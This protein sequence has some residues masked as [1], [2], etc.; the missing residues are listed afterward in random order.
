MASEKPTEQE[1]IELEF[2]IRKLVREKGIT[3]ADLVQQLNEKYEMRESAPSMSRYLKAGNIP[4]WK[5]KRIAELL[6]YD[7]K[8]ER[9]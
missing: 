8:F 2:M 9:K 4:L 6:G 3:I 1:V 7:L 5:A